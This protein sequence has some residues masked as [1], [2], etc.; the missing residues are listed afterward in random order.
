M[1][2]LPWPRE[3]RRGLD[4]TSYRLNPAPFH[5]HDMSL[6]RDVTIDDALLRVALRRSAEEIVTLGRF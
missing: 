2:K 4:D 5:A 1:A 3:L 6:A